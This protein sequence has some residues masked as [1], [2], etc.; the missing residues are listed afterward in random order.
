[1]FFNPKWINYTILG[2][3]PIIILLSYEFLKNILKPLIGK[4]PYMPSSM[5]GMGFK[6]GGTNGY[7]KNRKVTRAD[8]LF[9]ALHLILPGLIVML[10]FKLFI[11]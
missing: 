7:P 5:E 11:N 10:L 9:G 3:T 6:I 2:L 4:Y 8:V 1:M